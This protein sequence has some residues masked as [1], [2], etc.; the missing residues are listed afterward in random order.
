M[1]FSFFFFALLAVWCFSAVAFSYPELRDE[2]TRYWLY[3][4][5]LDYADTV[6]TNAYKWSGADYHGLEIGLD[7]C[8]AAM[9]LTKW[10]DQRLAANSVWYYKKLLQLDKERAVATYGSYQCGIYSSVLELSTHS[11]SNRGNVIMIPEAE[12]GEQWVHELCTL[13]LVTYIASDATELRHDFRP[14]YENTNCDSRYD[15]VMVVLEPPTARQIYLAN[16]VQ[17]MKKTI[18]TLV[19][20]SGNFKALL[21]TLMCA[22]VVVLA[23]SSGGSSGSSSGLSYDF[24]LDLLH[25]VFLSHLPGTV[26]REDQTNTKYDDLAYQIAMAL[27]K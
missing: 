22:R 27:S 17:A 16:S 8:S 20:D 2:E 3:W 6:C 4:Y 14:L 18:N 23:D 7:G 1:K 25:T 12:L 13:P 26:L 21:D 11:L 15:V 5:R 19:F 9:S 10:T 24:Q